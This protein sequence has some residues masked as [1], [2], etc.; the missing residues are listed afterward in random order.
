[1]P[2]F[3]GA[4]P[5]RKGRRHGA[6]LRLFSCLRDFPVHELDEQQGKNRESH[7]A[8]EGQAVAEGYPQPAAERRNE[9]GGNVVDG[10]GKAHAGRNVGG[11]GDL[12]EEGAHGNG[13]VEGQ[14]VENIHDAR[15][16]RAVRP[17]IAEEDEE[18]RGILY[19]EKSAFTYAVDDASYE[20][21]EEPVD[22]VVHEIE[23]GHGAHGESELE[24]EFQ[25]ISS[26]WNKVQLPLVE[27]AIKTDE[28]LLLGSTDKLV[29]DIFDALATLQKMLSYIMM[30]K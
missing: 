3:P 16:I 23:H 20:R 5:F 14:A 17:G 6:E 15:K 7:A 29:A 13:E 10:L 1:M 11:I 28:N 27:Q 24:Q 30:I 9:N 26:Y 19:G 22:R 8:V 4:A 18:G 25:K 21:I 12:L 2:S